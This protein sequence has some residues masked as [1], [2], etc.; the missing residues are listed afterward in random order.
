MKTTVCATVCA[1]LLGV[2]AEASL[3]EDLEE[4]TRGGKNSGQLL[5]KMC[6]SN[7][8]DFFLFCSQGERF[9]VRCFAE[10]TVEQ[11]QKRI[12]GSIEQVFE[13]ACIATIKNELGN[14]ELRM[15]QLVGY[16]GQVGLEE[17]RCLDQLADE[18]KVTSRG[19]AACLHLETDRRLVRHSEGLHGKWGY[20]DGRSGDLL[21]EHLFAEAQPFREG[22]AVVREEA[23]TPYGFITYNGESW[24]WAIK[25]RFNKALSFKNGKAIVWTDG[26]RSCIDRK[27][28]TTSCD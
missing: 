7:L 20:L 4:I 25:P 13:L 23:S 17:V 6:R 8:E 16:C 15:D 3:L 5:A 26:E 10:G 11:N 2:S 9:N 22:V 19:F 18:S 27:G 21:I 12:C 24:S 14:L 28:D 1:L